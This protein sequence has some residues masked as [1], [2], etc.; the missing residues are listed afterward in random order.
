MKNGFYKIGKDVIQTEINALKKLRK[1]LNK[2][3]DKIVQT[4][5]KCRGKVIFS[6]V[7]KSG[8]VSKKISSTL[9]SFGISSF[10]VDA[11]LA[12]MVIWV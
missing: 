4:I 1:S 11:G 7:G 8:I 3:F 10:Y 9:S 6:G 2:N 12:H 5:L